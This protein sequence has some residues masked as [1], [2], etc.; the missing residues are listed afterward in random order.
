MKMS[1]LSLARDKED[2]L[3]GEEATKAALM[4]HGDRFYGRE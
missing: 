4:D 2:T 1:S 3:S